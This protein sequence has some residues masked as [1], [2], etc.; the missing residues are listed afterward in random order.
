MVFKV[1]LMIQPHQIKYLDIE[2]TSYCNLHCPQCDRF[3]RHGR[4]NKHMTLEHL[5]FTK[6]LD[7]LELGK[8]TNLK[9][10]KFEGDHGDPAMHPRLLDFLAE[11]SHV[12]QLE[13]V[14]NASLHNQ[15]WWEK[16]ATFKNLSVT[17]SID[18]LSDTNKLYRIN[19]NF[20]K[21]ISNAT[22]FIKSGGHAIWKFIVFRHNEHQV[23]QARD[24]ADSLGFKSFT[25]HVSNRNFYDNNEFP[26]MLDGQ[27]Q[28]W[29]L[30]MS[31]TTQTRQDSKTIMMKQ[32]NSGVF[33]PPVCSWLEKGSIYIDYRGN[34]IP[35][36]MTSGLMWRKDISSQLWR[37]IVGDV[38]SIN[39]Y[40]H[41]LSTVLDSNFYK[42]RLK[43]SFDSIKTV[44]HVC[45]GH[46]S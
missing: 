43:Q 5:D 18:G 6:I 17:F 23:N 25:A 26:V 21:I 28:G 8:L 13:V 10:V 41:P 34:L 31:S 29:N 7:N 15:K 1:L 45:A 44:H 14:T 35:C 30:M 42:T 24:L 11:L 9:T 32:V 40:H 38:D 3:D 22:T 37:K 27:Y 19:S 20:D 36:C 33:T 46:C 4:L 2:C 16:L 39:L 12:P